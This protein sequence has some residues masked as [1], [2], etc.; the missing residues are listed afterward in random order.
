MKT[1]VPI[2]LAAALA[3]APA[4]GQETA[5]PAPTRSQAISGPWDPATRLAAERE[6][7]QALAF[8]DG[9]WRGT[10]TTERATGGL[11]HTERVGTLLGGTIRLVE[12]R[13]YDSRG[14]S[15]FNAFGVITYDP[16]R[17]TYGMRAHAMGYAADLPFEV[18]PDGF[19]WTQPMGTNVSIHYTATVRDGEWHE[20][21]DRVAGASPPVRVFEM[22]LRRIGPSE[23]PQAD[24]VPPR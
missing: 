7:M 2:L 10:A 16:V 20:V 22:R 18:R 17:R 11:V 6:A 21:G 23:W 3:A 8:L 5:P 14:E 4:P 12:G 15:P 19:S 13:S 1:I 24:S 9:T